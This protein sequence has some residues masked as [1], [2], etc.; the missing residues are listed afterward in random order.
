MVRRNWMMKILLVIIYL[1]FTVL[2]LMLMKGGGNAGE[3]ALKEGTI[4]FGISLI[5][6]LGF[7][8]Y[9]VSF[10]LFTR[11]V[12]MFDLSYIYPICAGA[13]QILTLIGAYAYFKDEMSIQSVGGAILI[14]LGIIIMN[15]KQS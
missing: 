7:V 14:I 10:L 6:L 13:T 5:S 11:I 9:L 4:N 8:C 3:F 15:W 1:F 2:G 12:M